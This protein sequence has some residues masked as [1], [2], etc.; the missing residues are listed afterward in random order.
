MPVLTDAAASRIR[1]VW[2]MAIGAIAAWLIT[3]AWAAPIL[4][5][6]DQLGMPVTRAV[7][8][9]AISWALGALVYLA[10]RWLEGRHGQSRAARWAR[11]AGRWVLS[12]GLKT[13]QPTYP[14]NAMPPQLRTL[15]Q[16]QP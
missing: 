12:L 13:G 16:R 10:G 3:R 6:L 11:A 5:A 9:T 7:L 8:A 1:T 4:H 2:P 15:R 14:A